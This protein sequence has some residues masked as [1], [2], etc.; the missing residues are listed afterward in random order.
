MNFKEF[1]RYEW[2]ACKRHGLCSPLSGF[3]L[4]AY[5]NLIHNP[6]AEALEWLP[7]G[8]FEKKEVYLHR[9]SVPYCPSIKRTLIDATTT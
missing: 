1:W 2:D 5:L 3:L 9:D 6:P 7:L 8:V 4:E